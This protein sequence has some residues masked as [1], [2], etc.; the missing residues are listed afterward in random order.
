MTLPDWLGK[1]EGF[2]AGALGITVVTTLLLLV[3][4][5]DQSTWSQT[6]TLVWG[7]VVGGGAVAA[8][9]R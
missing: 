5:I 3:R 7:S 1:S 2:V 8:F 9:R 6:V 4:V